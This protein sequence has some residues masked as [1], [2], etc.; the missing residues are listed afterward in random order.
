VCPGGP[1]LRIVGLIWKE[2]VAVKW[3][4][5]MAVC[6]LLLG[7]VASAV[8]KVVNGSFEDGEAVVSGVRTEDILADPAL[9]AKVLG[10]W[11][12]VAWGTNEATTNALTIVEMPDTPEGT[13]AAQ[14]HH[15]ANQI[16][17]FAYSFEP[18]ELQAGTSYE[19]TAKIR[20]EGLV[21]QGA[22]VNVE[23]WRGG[24][25]SGSV[26]SEHLNGTNPWR[27]AKI[28]FVAPSRRY[29]I[30]L[31]LWA[32]GGPGKA[33]FDDVSIRRIARPRIDV[34]KRHVIDA[35]FWGMFTC[36]GNYLHQF[37]KDMKAAGVYWQRQGLSSL[38]PEQQAFMEDNGMA[39][40]SCIDGLP[41]GKDPNDPCYPVTDSEEVRK[42]VQVIAAKAGPSIRILEVFNEPNTHVGWT[43]PAYANLLVLA[44]QTLKASPKGQQILFGT[45][46]FTSP[47]IGYTEAC[48]KRGADKVL[49]I[50]LVHPYAVDEPLDSQLWA[51][52]DV[53]NRTGRP[54]LAIAINETGFPT[55]DP[56]TGIEVNPWFVS[57]KDQA[58][59]VVKVHLQAI[60]HRLSFV[61]YLNWND[62]AQEPS[63]QA[64]NMGLVRLDGSPKPAL[65]AYTT[66]TR[67]L[68]Q[69][70]RI[71][72][73]DYG[74]DGTR[75]YRFSRE[76][77]KPVWAVW[78]ALQDAEVTVDVGDENVFPTDI[79]GTK[80]TVTPVLGSVTL[81]AGD[82]PVYLVPVE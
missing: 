30:K 61:T 3:V 55:W 54:D 1:G 41:A 14:I 38:A 8:P 64:K 80:L 82:S 22:F 16:S 34:S 23:F 56:G 40:E 74:A 43:L 67:M 68:G 31:S 47:Q 28:Q 29:H 76:Q 10:R 7:G 52:A 77:G 53:C 2:G 33:W 21:G 44:G 65:H 48:L 66:M 69:K 20:T 35:P 36:Y 19:V 27:E 57:E 15:E 63:D 12:T 39:F 75:T 62:F 24:Y 45:G 17:A 26:D 60:A 59:M 49:D 11:I 46:G 25:G 9:M 73:W 71:L 18:A 70:P 78:N 42:L 51:L 5:V 81:R 72:E 50:I 37:G 79:F 32:F 4:H 13:F 6:V 58:I